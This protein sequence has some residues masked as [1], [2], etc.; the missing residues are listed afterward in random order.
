M[1]SPEKPRGDLTSRIFD[2][3][4]LEIS[5][6]HPRLHAM[7]WIAGF[8]PQSN[9][10]TLTKL[11]RRAG[12]RIGDGTIFAG[13]PRLN[14]GKRL[15]E[16]LVVGANCFIDVGCTFD[17]VDNVVVG[18]HVTIGPQAMVLTSSHELG[19]TSHRAGPLSLKS[20]VIHDGAWLGPRCVIL[21]GVTVGE[22]AIVAA[23]ALVVKDVA[24]NT[25]VGGIP[26]RTLEALEPT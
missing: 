24:P 21:P 12:F 18:D 4:K 19:P 23:G 25:R 20:V 2:A 11:L 13:L 17:L 7:N 3:L 15:F 8:I 9:D 14:G 6:F 10:E 26:A 22:G 16:H 1:S 5:G